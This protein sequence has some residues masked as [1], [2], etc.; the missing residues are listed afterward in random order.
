MVQKL[1]EGEYQPYVTEAVKKRALA[2]R[3]TVSKHQEVLIK[4]LQHDLDSLADNIDM[5]MS[6]EVASIEVGTVPIEGFTDDVES[7][8]K[9]NLRKICDDLKTALET[10]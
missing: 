2:K 8:V 1:K 4:E 7:K 9:E 5:T 3:K 10:R 6:Q